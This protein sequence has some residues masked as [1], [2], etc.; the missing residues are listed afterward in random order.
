MNLEEEIDQREK[1]M[2]E[3]LTKKMNA[4]EDLLN[5]LQEM[6]EQYEKIHEMFEIVKSD[7]ENLVEE[8]EALMEHLQNSILGIKELKNELK[9]NEKELIEMDT[10]LRNNFRNVEE[11]FKER[12]VLGNEN[13]LLQNEIEKFQEIAEDQEIH[14][15]QL[16]IRI[17]HLC[18]YSELKERKQKRVSRN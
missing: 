15:E 11:H 13:L 17:F 7:N 12:E 18:L 9:V 3:K 8:R 2:K 4:N 14:K 6:E 1:M 5:R 16:L 10:N